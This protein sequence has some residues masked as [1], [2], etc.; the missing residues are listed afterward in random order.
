MQWNF[1]SERFI[2]PLQTIRGH[3]GLHDHGLVG[4]H[5]ELPPVLHHLAVR[6]DGEAH[7]GERGSALVAERAHDP[8]PAVSGSSRLIDC[9]AISIWSFCDKA[10]WS[11]ARCD[12]KCAGSHASL[13][14]H[15]RCR[16]CEQLLG[17]TGPRDQPHRALGALDQRGVRLPAERGVSQR[18][19][20]RG[21]CGK[22]ARR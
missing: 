9:P 5:I 18:T 3:A 21:P 12:A 15:H 4:A 11:N 6:A 7:V 13:I 10:R 20:L 17:E 16:R 8:S 19:E 2:K 22:R 1:G 14:L